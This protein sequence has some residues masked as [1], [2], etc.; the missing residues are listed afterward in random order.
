MTKSGLREQAE[1][2][3]PAVFATQVAKQHDD[4]HCAMNAGVKI[5]GE[6]C[7]SSEIKIF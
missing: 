6:N 5:F 2:V 4:P 3:E 1:L 7:S